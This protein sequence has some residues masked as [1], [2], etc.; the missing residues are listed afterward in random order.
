VREYT[1]ASGPLRTYDAL[2]DPRFEK[3]RVVGDYHTILLTEKPVTTRLHINAL[4]R[5]VDPGRQTVF[6][7]S[8]FSPLAQGARTVFGIRDITGQKAAALAKKLWNQ[9][10][11]NWHRLNYGNSEDDITLVE[12]KNFAGDFQQIAEF[13]PPAEGSCFFYLTA[14]AFEVFRLYWERACQGSLKSKEDRFTRDVLT[15]AT[16]AKITL[17]G[18][19]DGSYTVVVNPKV[20]DVDKV[21]DAL[22]AAGEKAGMIITTA[23]G[24]F[25]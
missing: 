10:A 25:G 9:D 23:P 2:F 21:Q 20:P 6:V 8:L 3:M 14:A 11:L 7:S 22:V 15:L 16:D 19:K 18:D 12:L 24:L 4:R 13:I 1:V 17:W 5:T